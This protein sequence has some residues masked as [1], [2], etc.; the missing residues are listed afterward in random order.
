MGI[1]SKIKT[2][3][4]ARER[5][6]SW[7]A[8]K[9][10]YSRQGLTTSLEKETVNLSTLIKIAKA[11][12]LSISELMGI[13]LNSTLINSDIENDDI[14]KT[15]EYKLDYSETM[16]SFYKR[17][18]EDK[19]KLLANCYSTS[20]LRKEI[21]NNLLSYVLEKEGIDKK[22]LKETIGEHMPL[23]KDPSKHLLSYLSS[24]DYI[25]N[26]SHFK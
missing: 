13:L 9:I 8:Q 23:I 19:E 14:I 6:I 7:L 21:F 18:I 17:E 12:D 5:T 24:L 11:L 15:L 22:D 16:I 20:K 2:L 10:D 25:I 3:L 1:H 4:E 26:K